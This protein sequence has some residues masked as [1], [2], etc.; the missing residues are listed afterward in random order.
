M[1]RT[2]QTVTAIA[3]MG[4]LV[5]A[6]NASAGDV[7]LKARAGPAPATAAKGTS[8]SPAAGQL[9][10]SVTTPLGKVAV[11]V[12]PTALLNQ[13]TAADLVTG[14][15]Q[16]VGQLGQAPSTTSQ[17]GVAVTQPPNADPTAQTAEEAAE[18]DTTAAG[19]QETG[20]SLG[21][22]AATAA[23]QAGLTPEQ[24]Q[25][26]QGLQGQ[27][28]RNEIDQGAFAN[29]VQ[30]LSGV[31]A[32]SHTLGGL[33]GAFNQAAGTGT[34]DPLNLT[35]VQRQQAQDIATRLHTDIANLR[36]AAHALIVELLTPTQQALLN[37]SAVGQGEQAGQ[38]RLSQKLVP[39]Q[40]AS[41][42]AA[43]ASSGAINS[44]TTAVGSTAGGATPVLQ[45]PADRLQLTDAQKTEIEQI[46]A[47]LRTAVQARHQQARDEFRA[48]LTPQQQAVL[49]QM[50]QSYGTN[51]TATSAAAGGQQVEQVP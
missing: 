51:T 34:V 35:D 33:G 8:T 23:S 14:F 17:G 39:A 12:N 43:T 26:I 48:I 46:R 13:L 42:S 16:F 15:Q 44:G 36:Q 11:G 45:N 22:D 24:E 5:F 37:E 18:S 7:K 9:K 38:K 30:N 50:E 4:L 40:T 32:P 6:A 47:A 3:A 10:A 49:D 41:G 20:D 2:I 25:Q 29:Q 27:L 21:L 1:T 31:A 28:D 19:Q